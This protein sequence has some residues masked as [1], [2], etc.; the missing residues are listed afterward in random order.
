MS[1]FDFKKIF[2]Q[3]KTALL[4]L[5]QFCF[6]GCITKTEHNNA[7]FNLF[8]NKNQL[9]KKMPV[10]RILRGRVIFFSIL[11]IK[12]QFS[13]R[14]TRWRN[15]SVILLWLNTPINFW[16]IDRHDTCLSPRHLK[17]KFPRL[18][19]K[20]FYWPPTPKLYGEPYIN[21]FDVSQQCNGRK[22]KMFLCL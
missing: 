15:T 13:H 6:Q 2:W 8:W 9:L 14:R 7:I 18:W 1:L 17:F 10:I 5:H 4:L 19:K 16:S 12:F 22:L 20:V 21:D 3:L 11:W